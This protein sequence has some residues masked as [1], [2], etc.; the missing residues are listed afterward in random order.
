MSEKEFYNKIELLKVME[1]DVW[2]RNENSANEE[3]KKTFKNIV[4][5]ETLR[6]NH[7]EVVNSFISA[8]KK[9]SPN[10]NFIIF[11]QDNLFDLV[12]ENYKKN[13]RNIFLVFFD[14]ETEKILSERVDI[15]ENSY[16][17]K[18]KNNFFFFNKLLEQDT[19]TNKVKKDIWESFLNTIN[20][21][22]NKL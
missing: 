4:I 14:S 16:T 15:I 17:N 21:K 22:Y 7:G 9:E 12:N 5:L 2:L 3:D 1:A 13:R 18:L 8:A 19:I 20:F 11:K 10:I 6:N